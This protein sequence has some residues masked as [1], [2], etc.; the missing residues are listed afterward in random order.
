MDSG[1]PNPFIH[2][3]FLEAGSYLGNQNQEVMA[4]DVLSTG[5]S[6]ALTQRHPARDP[7]RAVTLRLRTK[8]DGEDVPGRG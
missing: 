4:F 8:K 1:T 2:F 3:V 6:G 7:T 5:E